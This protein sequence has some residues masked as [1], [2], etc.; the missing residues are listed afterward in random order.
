MFKPDFFIDNQWLHRIGHRLEG[1]KKAGGN[2]FQARCPY[3]GDSKK[4]KRKKRFYFYTKKQSLNF[5]CKNCDASG[6]FWTFMQEQVPD[7]FD[8][9]KKEQMFKHFKRYEPNNNSSNNFKREDEE[10]YQIE[11][12]NYEPVCL[13]KLIG[14]ME[15]ISELPESHEA[16][17]YLVKRG[18]SKKEYGR[19]F[20]A[21][22]FK[23]LSEV[24]SYKELSE[25]FPNEPRIVIPFFN[26]DLNVTMMQGRSLDPKSSLKYITIKTDPELEKIY[27]LENVKRNKTVY[28]VEGPLDSLFVDNCLASCDSSLTKVPADVY[29]FDNQ[30]RNKEIVELMEDCIEK[31]N[32]LVV[33][34]NSPNGKEDINDMIKNGTPQ[35]DLMKIIKERT[36]KGLKARIELTNWRR[37]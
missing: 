30:P 7:L 5:D 21:Q 14:L 4:D 17:Q 25:R 2:A 24:V 18:F 9:Y 11:E 19:L 34:P 27:G 28:C 32:Q 23:K 29:I 6:S 31:G 35:K 10:Q 37:V 20:Y 1:F 16:V 15:P 33:W 26:K 12:E 8:E 13:S 36:F 3:C 22:D